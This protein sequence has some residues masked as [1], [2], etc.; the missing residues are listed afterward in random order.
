MFNSKVFLATLILILATS[1]KKIDTETVV[2]DKVIEE[3]QTTDAKV[4][5]I[6]EK[7][8]GDWKRIDYPY[9]TYE[10]NGSTAKL[11]SEGQAEE[12]TFDPYELSTNCRYAD[13]FNAELSDQEVII[14]NPK[15]ESCEIISVINDTLR[16]SD[17]ERSFEILYTRN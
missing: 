7:L 8:Q 16:L 2:E 15:F 11:I 4:V 3:I 6:Q 1:C 13:N 10:F 12:P 14:I 17:L 5:Q 9:S